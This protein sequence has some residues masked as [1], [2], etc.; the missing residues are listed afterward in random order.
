[1]IGGEHQV[2]TTPTKLADDDRSCRILTI[3]LDNNQV[4]R[5]TFRD[6]ELGEAH[7]YLV[8]TTDSGESWTFGPYGAGMGIKPSEIYI[9]GTAS[10][11]ILWN[12]LEA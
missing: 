9:A 12:G 11:V 8:S 3:R 5:I 2:K 6:D 4:S 10:A 1:M 7:G